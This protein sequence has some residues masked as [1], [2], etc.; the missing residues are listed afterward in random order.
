MQLFPLHALGMKLPSFACKF[1][2][3]PRG[4]GNVPSDPLDAEK[5][6]ASIAATGALI[7]CL[8]PL[9]CIT[10]QGRERTLS[11]DQAGTKCGALKHL[12]GRSDHPE[13][14]FFCYPPSLLA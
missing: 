8:L 7:G 12:S 4:R 10:F 13:P 3:F 2:N 5:A 1:G 9:A 6:I 14:K 11:Q